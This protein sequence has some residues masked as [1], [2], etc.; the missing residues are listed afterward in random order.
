MGPFVMG[1]EKGRLGAGCWSQRYM[2][3]RCGTVLV[4]RTLPGA[5]GGWSVQTHG[6][7]VDE[8]PGDLLYSVCT[9]LEVCR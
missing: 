2:V 3:C 9:H 8:L 1:A 5:N 6:S 4:W 7:L